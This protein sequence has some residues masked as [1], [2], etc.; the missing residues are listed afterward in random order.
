MRNQLRLRRWSITDLPK[1]WFQRSQTADETLIENVKYIIG[2][3]AEKGDAA[4]IEFTEKFDKVKLGRESLKVSRE[5][6]AAAYNRVSKQQI[7]ALELI[8]NK[9]TALENCLLEHINIETT[10]QGI[11]VRCVLRP[12]ESVGCYVPGGQAAYPSSVVMTSAPAKTAGVPRIVV[13][14]PPNV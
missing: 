4:L 8:K 14:T 9:V 13:C 10:T 3:V 11:R 5:E 12:L 7:E 6:I 1:N 2:K